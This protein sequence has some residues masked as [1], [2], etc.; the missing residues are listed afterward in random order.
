M[1]KLE[2]KEKQLKLTPAEERRQ[3]HF[4]KIAEDL[5]EKGYKRTD[6]T[7]GIIK[8]GCDHL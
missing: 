3:A 1:V 5:K 8:P 2:E 4:E 6:L 7:I